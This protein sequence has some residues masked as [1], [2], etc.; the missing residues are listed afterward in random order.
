MLSCVEAPDEGRS[1]QAETTQVDTKWMNTNKEQMCV[2]SYEHRADGED[3]LRVRVGRHVP[4]PH[5]GQTA[6]S[7]VQRRH[8]A[9]PHGRASA[10]Q[11]E[12]RGARPRHGLAPRH[13]SVILA[14]VPG[15]LAPD[16]W[17]RHAPVAAAAA[18][19]AAV[20]RDAA[21]WRGDQGRQRGQEVG[22]AQTLGQ[23]VEP[24]WGRQRWKVED[25]NIENPFFISPALRHVITGAQNF[26][27]RPFKAE[28][29]LLRSPPAEISRVLLLFI[30]SAA[31]DPIF[32]S[33]PIFLSFGRTKIL[34]N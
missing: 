23:L 31:I 29:V 30:S 14:G 5:A 4:E 19:V 26:S 25:I 18:A 22:G 20:G 28:Y 1:L 10:Q 21:D 3:L 7:E 13:V 12:P 9:A 6:Q 11:G 32:L 33:Y 2:T 8:V 34:Q 15:G 17:P 16:L 27:W 24:T